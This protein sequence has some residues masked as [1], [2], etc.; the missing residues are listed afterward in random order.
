VGG[1]E[2]GRVRG[3]SAERGRHRTRSLRR[4]VDGGP[5]PGVDRGGGRWQAGR[6]GSL[7][8][9]PEHH[10]DCC[11]LEGAAYGYAVTLSSFACAGAGP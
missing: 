6:A 5:A 7:F 4:A 8:V 1:R 2:L 9:P 10:K 3:L 11:Y